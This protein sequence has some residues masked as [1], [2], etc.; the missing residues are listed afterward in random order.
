MYLLANIGYAQGD[1]HLRFQPMFGGLPLQTD[2]TY[3]NEHGDSL[4]IDGFK[5]YITNVKLITTAGDLEN[6]DCKYLVDIANTESCAE[7]VKYVS[8][9]YKGIQFLIGVDSLSN[10][11]GAN[12]G[13]LDPMM[14]MYWTWNSGYIM[15][16]LEG[17]SN[18]C[19]TAHHRF[20]YHIGGYTSPYVASRTVV[21]PFEKPVSKLDSIIIKADAAMWFSGNVS[22][23]EINSVLIPGMPAMVVA[24]KYAK[25]FSIIKLD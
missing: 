15:A 9:F 6:L 21:L 19:P 14:G 23:K 11:S 3:V 12:S 13:V 8:G 24:D 5:F 17:V 25:M 10:V 4:Q 22:L 20:E 1:F 2:I 16:K 7:V 18:V